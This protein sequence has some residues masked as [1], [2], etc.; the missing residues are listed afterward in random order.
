VPPLPPS[1]HAIPI[2]Q[3][4]YAE[5]L[6]ADLATAVRG[7][8]RFDRGSRAMYASDASNYRHIPIGL[9]IPRDAEDVVAAVSVCRKYGAPVLPR[10]AGTSLAGQSC[11]VAVVL[12]FTQHMNAILELDPARRFARVQPGVVLD[13]LRDRAEAHSLTFGPDPS[14]HN[15]CTLGGMI[16][17]NS[18][19]THS[20]LA[21]KTVD[22]IESL[23]VLLYDGTELTV[24]P[25]GDDELRAIVA[26][27][28]RRG[29][30]YR[31]LAGL[32]DRYADL[33]RARF[34]NI[35]RR[36][37][38]FNL[39]QLLP[40]NGFN[41]AR[42]LVGTEGTCVTVLEATTTLIPSPQHRVLVALGYPDAYA[43]ADHVP[44]ILELDPIGLEGFEGAMIDGLKRK[45]APNLDL[46]PKGRGILLVEFG[47]DGP[48]AAGA[49]ADRLLERVA[50][51]PDA[52]RARRYSAAE[53]RTVWKIRES[54]PRA[55]GAGPN[56][57]LRWEGWDD[58][59]V[60]PER[61]GPYLRDLRRLLDEFNY[62]A[63]Y[64]GHFGHGCIHMQ[65]SFDLE[66]EAGV[67][68]FGAF[69]DRAADL[70]VSYGGSLS[71]EH[72]DGQ[73][74]ASL[75][76]KM[77]GPELVGAFREF[78]TIWDPD[79][80]MNPHKVVD[81]YP[82]TG[83]LRLGADYAPHE[84]ATH[85]QFPDDRGSF[86]KAAL[87]C[88][89]LGACRKHDE[90]T[91]CPS[92]RVTLE[93]QH[94]TRGRARM[95]FEMLQG[96]VVEKGW[97]NEDVKASLDLCLSCKACKSECPTNV[98]MATYRS[99]FLS[100]YYEGQRRPLAAYAFGFVDR[101]ARL[102]A[103]APRLANAAVRTPGVGSL[104]KG[105]L[106][107]AP[108]RELPRFAAQTFRQ[109]AGKHGVRTIGPQDPA[110][111]GVA[112]LWVDT[113]SNHFHPEVLRAAVGVLEHAG[114]TVVIPRDPL[115]CGRPLYDFGFLAQA[116]AYLTQVLDALAVPLETGA[117]IVVLEPSC[118][119]VFRDEAR[120]L[121]PDH[122][123]ADRL[124][125]QTVLLGEL[126][127]RHAPGYVPPRLERPVLLHGHCH[128]KAV[129]SMSDELSLL[130][131]MG[132]HVTMPEPGCCG[133]A[134]PFGLVDTTYPVAQA[135]GERALLPA[136][137]QADERT[138]IVSNGFSCR[139]QIWQ[140]GKRRAI[141]L[142]EAL[143]LALGEPS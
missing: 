108:G 130:E 15:R 45:N 137:R 140:G 107:L 6:A 81:P 38:G 115:C 26:A 132:A 67:R 77:F 72:G 111:P 135:I 99:E 79:H 66:S 133:M 52:P 8:V 58:A 19:G 128:Q 87:R 36:V 129:M 142:V 9:V 57:P 123:G 138:L 124:R 49:K 22:N 60:A 118:A 110:P 25:T 29:D 106:G 11:N 28:G 70:V 27:G 134:G 1:S 97:W 131:K 4:P 33:I 54:G 93:E 86:A 125:R 40:E 114:F 100:H 24:G 103:R 101:W 69:L 112:V 3:F 78:K 105:T 59:S 63:A 85:F 90:G 30:I 23:R 139:E 55:A 143:S 94:S 44:D 65:V 43:A 37:S 12:D 31:R 98:D 34:P 2:D 88:T 62:Q 42:A 127:E 119:S 126:L 7:D 35:P 89:G 76:P 61:L 41:V 109:W 50:R 82:P 68:T 80:R 95:L 96:E 32:R 116:K 136:V 120:G 122:P 71:G 75:L 74:R 53:A 16:G 56:M 18:C 47:A 113:F 117:H 83:N 91:M 141:H 17:N 39:D 20:L 14:T 46:I 73:A 13:D 10:G 21:G 102:A 121:F 64:Y 48:D 5:A 92:Y 104:M 84:P 51:L